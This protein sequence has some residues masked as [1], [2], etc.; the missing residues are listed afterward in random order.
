MVAPPFRFT[1]LALSD[2]H[3]QAEEILGRLELEEPDEAE[4][5]WVRG[6]IDDLG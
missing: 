2:L 3:K 5:A 4:V 6:L 1:R